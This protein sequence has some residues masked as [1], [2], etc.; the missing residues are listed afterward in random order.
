M[1]ID[2]AKVRALREKR[3]QSRGDFAKACG[4]G[5]S[6]IKYWELGKSKRVLPSTVHRI[7]VR[8]KVRREQLLDL[9]NSDTGRKALPSFLAQQ[10]VPHGPAEFLEMMREAAIAD[11]KGDHPSAQLLYRDA[12]AK[13][14]D[15]DAAAKAKVIV[16][17]MTSLD[18]GEACEEAARGLENELRRLPD[19]PIAHWA[20][21]HLALAYRRMAERSKGSSYLRTAEKMFREV[22]S[23]GDSRQRVAA[24]HQLGCIL[25]VRASR[26]GRPKSWAALLGRARRHFERAALRWRETENFR[27]G[28]ALR[29]LA[30]IAEQ[31]GDVAAAHRQLLGA[32]EVFVRHECYRYRDQVRDHL[33]RLVERWGSLAVKLSRDGVVGKMTPV[34]SRPGQLAAQCASQR[35]SPLPEDLMKLRRVPAGNRRANKEK[36]PRQNPGGGRE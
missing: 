22:W 1:K 35:R 15:R 36:P 14:G 24:V 18:D 8:L 4:V 20:R 10:I 13:I 16:R 23:K 32:F 19:G 25:L 3:C 29:R 7:C 34:K 6:T 17:Y 21:Y 12:L 28:Y 33:E 26:E 30:E 31:E 27:E 2:G 5:E 9:S 11:M